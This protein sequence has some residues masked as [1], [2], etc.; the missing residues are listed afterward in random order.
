MEPLNP[1]ES[2]TMKQ[3]LCC[4]LLALPSLC[5]AAYPAHPINLIVPFPAGAG[6]DQTARTIAACME[7]KLDSARIVV[8]NK[9]GASGD[10]GLT[11]LARAEPDGYTI[12]L[13]NTPGVIS[14]PIERKTAYTLESFDFIANLVEDPGTISVHAD[15]PIHSIQDL[16]A[17]AK[18]KPGEITV[19]TQGVGSAGHIS[20]LSLEHAAGIQLS[21]VPFQGAAPAS[22]AL[23]GKVVDSTMANLG[24]AITFANGKPWRI[25][26]V[27]GDKRAEQAPDIPTF[28]D[29][30]YEVIGG[31]MRG[32]AGPRG[33]PA[34]VI[35]DLSR[36]V[37]ECNHDQTYLSRAKAS[38]QPLRYLKRDDYIASLKAVDRQLRELWT[39]KPWQQ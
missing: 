24:E 17:A 37:D 3:V 14:L 26:G 32:L 10:I 8:L 13:V 25:V 20:A 33:M 7:T 6:S 29:A 21:P 23:L 2:H 35:A 39:V 19:G 15:S 28:H 36:A 11:A 34:E 16:I 31:S 18:A 38:F 30:G 1:L 9:P 4:A 5:S 27:M 22:V 12:G